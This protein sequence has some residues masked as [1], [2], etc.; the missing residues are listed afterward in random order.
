M[1]ELD[2][3]VSIL[4]EWRRNHEVVVAEWRADQAAMRKDISH[5]AQM[6]SGL[7]LCP[8]PGDCLHIRQ[9]IMRLEAQASRL[10]DDMDARIDTLENV[11]L[12]AVEDKVNFFRGSVII[13]GSVASII[14]GA[15]THWLFTFLR[16]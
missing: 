8:A 13:I 7:K 10:M 11:R 16:K 4:E 1:S 12:R 6:M 9:D 14:V 15:L 5:I 3:R 2:A